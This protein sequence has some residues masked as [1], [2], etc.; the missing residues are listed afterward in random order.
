MILWFIVNVH[1][2][3]FSCQGAGTRNA[4]SAICVTGAFAEIEFP[5]ASSTPRQSEGTMNATCQ[6]WQAPCHKPFAKGANIMTTSWGMNIMIISASCQNYAI[7]IV[8]PSTQN[9]PTVS[10]YAR[11]DGRRTDDNGIND[12]SL[13]ILSKI[14]HSTFILYLSLEVDGGR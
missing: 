11:M 2:R 9:T 12:A 10:L 3:T 8:F 6:T 5:V 7:F 14:N 13:I 1:M 4:V